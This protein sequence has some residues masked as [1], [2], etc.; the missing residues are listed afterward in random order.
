M[1]EFDFSTLAEPL[2]EVFHVSVAFYKA[3]WGL[4]LKLWP[5]ILDVAGLVDRAISN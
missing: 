5:F 1:L 3:L 4:F 2:K